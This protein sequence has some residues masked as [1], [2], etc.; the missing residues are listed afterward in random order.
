MSG[1]YHVIIIMITAILL[2]FY[3]YYSL[4]YIWTKTQNFKFQFKSSD[5]KRLITTGFIIQSYWRQLYI[6]TKSRQDCWINCPTSFICLLRQDFQII[7]TYYLDNRYWYVYCI[8]QKSYNSLLVG[9]LGNF[10][11]IGTNILIVKYVKCS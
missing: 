9:Q 11:Q 2:L 7:E 8:S 5:F 6:E 10:N 3:I 1:W 4:F